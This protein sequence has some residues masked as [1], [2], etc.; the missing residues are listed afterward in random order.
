MPF[1]YIDGA[2]IGH[3]CRIGPFARIRPKTILAADVRIGNFVEIKENYIFVRTYERG[4][5]AETLSCGTGVT[6]SAL[7]Y[8]FDKNIEIVSIHTLGGKLTVSFE[9]HNAAFKNVFLEGEASF[10]FEGKIEIDG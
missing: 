10:V 1:S 2:N 9:K 6:A 3:A 5:E 7:A 8:A 4:V